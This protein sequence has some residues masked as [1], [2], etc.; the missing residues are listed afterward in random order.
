MVNNGKISFGKGFIES[1]R[2][3][4]FVKKL[5]QRAYRFWQ[6]RFMGKPLGGFTKFGNTKS[7]VEYWVDT[8]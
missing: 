3:R 5:K 2:R 6:T 1:F 8:P 4:S 7:V